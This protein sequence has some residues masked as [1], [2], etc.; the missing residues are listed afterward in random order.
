MTI[1]QL[2]FGGHM[3][4]GY[5]GNAFAVEAEGQL[6]SPNCYGGP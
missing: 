6:L 1:A 5:I 3:L 4:M 2:R